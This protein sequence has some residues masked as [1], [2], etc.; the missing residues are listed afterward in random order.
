MIA[1]DVKDD[2][3]DSLRIRQN[4]LFVAV[5]KGM[6][7]DKQKGLFSFAPKYICKISS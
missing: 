3:L 6:K 7:V 1:I 2:R 4:A 5:I